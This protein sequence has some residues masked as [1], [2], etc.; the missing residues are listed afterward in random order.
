MGIM[1]QYSSAVSGILNVESAFHTDFSEIHSMMTHDMNHSSDL[2]GVPLSII[3][4]FQ[5][6]KTFAVLIQLYW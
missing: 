1:C 4:Y 3:T 2:M 5:I 6:K